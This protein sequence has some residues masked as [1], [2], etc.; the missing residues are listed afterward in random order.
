MKNDFK[1]RLRKIHQGWVSWRRKYIPLFFRRRT[2]PE[3]FQLLQFVSFAAGE[4]A[5]GARVLDAGA[6]DRP[7]RKYFKHTKYESTD[8]KN[9]ESASLA[10]GHDFI[11][12]LDQIPKPD[13]HYDAIVSTQ[14]LEHV[15]YPQTVADEFF[16]ILRPGG[17][18]FITVPQAWGVHGEPY[19]FYYFTNFGLASILQS[20]GFKIIFIKPRGGIFWLL[21]KIIKVV[22]AYIFLQHLYQKKEDV[23]KFNPDF[24]AVVLFPFYLL[25]VPLCQVFIPFLFYYFDKLDRKK[26]FTL[27][28]ECYCIK[29]DLN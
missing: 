20:A 14:V 15:E 7:Y 16:R 8:F 6:G 21:G 29:P 22:P 27:G 3:M 18:L 23:L 2:D 25:V 11:C 28:Y 13:N 24:L 26:H 4:M 12:S 5:A 17:K 19:N 1:K 10:G 9:Y